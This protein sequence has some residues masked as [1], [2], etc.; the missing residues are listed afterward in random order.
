MNIRVESRFLVLVLSFGN[1]EDEIKFDVRIYGI[2]DKLSSRVDASQ[3]SIRSPV[4]AIAQRKTY[5]LTICSTFCVNST[6]NT[7]EIN[8]LPEIVFFNLPDSAMNLILD[9]RANKQF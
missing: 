4:S 3:D 2:I 9:S 1:F 8:N 5:F 6:G 7:R